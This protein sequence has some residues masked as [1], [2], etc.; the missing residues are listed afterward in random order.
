MS[1]LIR[2]FLTVVRVLESNFCPHMSAWS[3]YFSS[4]SLSSLSSCTQ[5]RPTRTCKVYTCTQQNIGPVFCD[6]AY[7]D[8]GRFRQFPSEDLLQLLLLQLPL[9]HLYL[10]VLLHHLLVAVR[11][12]AIPA[13]SE[14]GR[15]GG[16]GRTGRRRGTRGWWQSNVSEVSWS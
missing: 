10:L 15:Q 2:R 7:L 6:V 5:G 4:S 3:A 8:D 13:I 12:V 9:G 1:S 11:V 14:N 16:R